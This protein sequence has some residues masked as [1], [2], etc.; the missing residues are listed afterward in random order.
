M[1][2]N[3]QPS[4]TARL[5]ACWNSSLP[6]ATSPLTAS[7]EGNHRIRRAGKA[8]ERKRA[9]MSQLASPCRTCISFIGYMKD[10]IAQEKCWRPKQVG[11]SKRFAATYFKTSLASPHLPRSD[12]S[13]P[14][15][16]VRR[17][18]WHQ[19]LRQAIVPSSG[20]VHSQHL[21]PMLCCSRPQPGFQVRLQL[22]RIQNSA[23]CQRNSAPAAAGGHKE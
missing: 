3:T 18:C 19:Q 4:G 20:A 10:R 11:E 7:F 21:A 13:V 16:L 2:L 15:V 1:A 23:P 9:G 17:Q 14:Y 6:G 22:Q 5:I 12:D 8:K